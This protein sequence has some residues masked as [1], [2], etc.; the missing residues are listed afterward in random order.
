MSSTPGDYNQF[1]CVGTVERILARATTAAFLL[2]I[3]DGAGPPC[4]LVV[5]PPE[6]CGL[7]VAI[8]QRVWAKGSLRVEDVPGRRALH[9]LQCQFLDV[10]PAHR[11]VAS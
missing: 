7:A 11:R 5:W 1:I 4:F 3:H 10:L 6:G 9:Y 8:G 2:R